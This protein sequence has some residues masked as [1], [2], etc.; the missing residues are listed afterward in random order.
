MKKSKFSDVLNLYST[1]RKTRNIKILDKASKLS[2]EVCVSPLYTEDEKIGVLR[3]ILVQASIEEGLELQAKKENDESSKPSSDL[4]IR[5]V[6]L[7]LMCTDFISR[8]RDSL[9]HLKNTE[10]DAMISLLR[11]VVQLQELPAVERLYTATHF[12]NTQQYH[13]CY[14]CFADLALDRSLTLEYRLEA[15]KF[16]FSSGEDEERVVVR[17]ALLSIIQNHKYTCEERYNAIRAYIP[18]KGIRTM[19]NRKKLMIPH[20]E[21][22]VYVLQKSFFFDE[23]NDFRFRILSGQNLLQ[24]KCA[25]EDVRAKVIEV[26][27]SIGADESKTENGRADA[28]D[29][30]LRLGKDKDKI[31]AKLE[32]SN[33]GESSSKVAFK[34]LYTN[35]QNI[36]D[37]IISESIETY[38]EKIVEEPKSYKQFTWEEVMV[39]VTE[40]VRSV[41]PVS[42]ESVDFTLKRH[43]INNCLSRIKIDTATF[44]KYKITSI[45]IL[46]HVWSRINSQEF[47]A[48]EVVLLKKRLIE[49]FLD[50]D[51]TCSSGGSGRLINVFSGFDDT[52]KIGWENQITANVKGRVDAKIRTCTD[53]DLQAT[54]TFGMMEDADEDDKKVYIDFVLANL[55][56]IEKEL[57]AEF[58]GEGHVSEEDFKKYMQNVRKKIGS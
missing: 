14:P 32:L 33:I 7:R 29:V 56:S 8:W 11:R 5:S 31:R 39:G 51:D 50:M 36:H 44:T 2:T 57:H 49:E 43:A 12:Y 30:V 25:E 28:L 19:M 15:A 46:C 40:Y 45:E 21:D 16:L 41:L 9:V 22:F 54:L 26:L 37:D 47:N 53:S 38:I 4:E 17:D 18:N 10:A 3:E 6:N 55:E 48:D 34:T 27:F 23:D 35:S 1:Y 24:I 42:D 20:D 58:V 13:I 52:I